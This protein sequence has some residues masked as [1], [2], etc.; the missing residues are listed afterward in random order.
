VRHEPQSYPVVGQARLYIRK[1]HLGIQYMNQKP[2]SEDILAYS[3][4]I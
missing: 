2:L 1:Y 4:Y 3:S